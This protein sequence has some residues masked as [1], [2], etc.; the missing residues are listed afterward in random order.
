[1]KKSLLL[2]FLIISIIIYGVGIYYYSIT[3]SF[4]LL[5][6]TSII[7]AVAVSLYKS[8]NKKENNK[9]KFEVDKIEI[10]KENKEE[11]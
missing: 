3:K 2:V 4:T 1:M 5:L 6:I 11:K 10:N 7:I 8:Y 9:I